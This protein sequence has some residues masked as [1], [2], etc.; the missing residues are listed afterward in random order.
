MGIFNSF[1]ASS[2]FC[3]L[4]ITFAVWTQIR[5]VGSGSKPF[6]TL[7]VFLKEFFENVNFEK[8]SSDNNKS[9]KN[10]PTC[11]ELRVFWH[12]CW[13]LYSC[14]NTYSYS[15]FNPL[16]NERKSMFKS[17]DSRAV[18]TW[19]WTW[20]YLKWALCYLHDVI[21]KAS[22]T[23]LIISPL[24]LFAK[25]LRTVMTFWRCYDIRKFTATPFCLEKSSVRKW[26][27]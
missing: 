4:L 6:D 10:Y 7:I 18:W 19:V 2:N 24:L 11:K 27:F 1:L 14:I 23:R 16:S 15:C 17:G 22:R 3:C 9:M 25:T 21:P 26:T 5:T 12:I 20:K 8:R 13:N